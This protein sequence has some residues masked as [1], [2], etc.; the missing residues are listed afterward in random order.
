VFGIEQ[1]IG[2]VDN[3]ILFGI[4][5]VDDVAFAELQYLT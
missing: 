2:F 5:G 1:S 3:P 4:T